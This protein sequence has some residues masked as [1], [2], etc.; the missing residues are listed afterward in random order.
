[1]DK[2]FIFFGKKSN[3]LTQL[4]SGNIPD[5]SIVF[6]KDSKEI[7]NRGVYFSGG[8]GGSGWDFVLPEGQGIVDDY[9]TDLFIYGGDSITIG[10]S[11]RDTTLLTSEELKVKR[12][13]PNISGVNST[14]IVYDK[15]NLTSA[16]IQRILNTANEIVF[17]KHVVCSQGAGT[18]SVSDMRLK[19]VTS[20]INNALDKVLDLGTFKFKFT[21]QEDD[22]EHLGMSAQ[23][24]QE[25]FPEVVHEMQDKDKTLTVDYAQLVPVLVQAIQDQQYII[26]DLKD[27][28]ERLEN[29]EQ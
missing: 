17:S 18:S 19:K 9:N 5:T 24:L 8:S 12:P 29:K 15:G 7:Y 10:D 27:R 22:E 6:I 23:Q 2:R 1:M 13:N 26:D 14:Y 3:F 4:G 11:S 16:E 21:H 20:P 25:Y 28:L